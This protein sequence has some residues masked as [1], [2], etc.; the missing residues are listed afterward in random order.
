MAAS[1]AARRGRARRGRRMH[2]RSVHRHR[3]DDAARAHRRRAGVAGFLCL[4]TR[5]SALQP[6][7]PPL[8]PTPAASEVLDAALGGTH[9]FPLL[10]RGARSVGGLRRR[11]DRRLWRRR[12]QARISPI[13]SLYLPYISPISPLQLPDIFSR[14]H[15]AQ[16]APSRHGASTHCRHRQR[17]IPSRLVLDTLLGWRRRERAWDARLGGAARARGGRCGGGSAWGSGR[18]GFSGTTLPRTYK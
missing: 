13:S 3:R 9:R 11:L 6:W 10:C 17:G 14:R 18:A 2:Y 4:P 12:A 5:L 15:R 7:T 16:A 8:C 1:R